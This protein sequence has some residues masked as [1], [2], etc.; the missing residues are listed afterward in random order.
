MAQTF[1]IGSVRSAVLAEGR[2]TRKPKSCS[3]TW[4]RWS[5]R[6]LPRRCS[7]DCPRV[8]QRRLVLGITQNAV[9]GGRPKRCGTERFNTSEPRVN[10][11]QTVGALFADYVRLITDVGD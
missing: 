1:S 4:A 2:G 8:L 7:R 6:G 5:L 10:T 9:A 11:I 3:P